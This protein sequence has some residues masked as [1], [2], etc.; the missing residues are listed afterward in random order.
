MK[1]NFNLRHRK[2]S[3]KSLIYLNFY[4][5][6]NKVPFKFNT[7]L[8]VEPKF[9]DNRRQKVI[10]K[11]QQSVEINAKLQKIEDALGKIYND[12]VVTDN[13][14]LK[15][16]LMF[17][18]KRNNRQHKNFFDFA[19]ND[20]A[21]L[22][23]STKPIWDTTVNVLKEFE[24]HFGVIGFNSFDK[25]FYNEFKK[26]C[27]DTKKYSNST[28]STRITHLKTIINNA[29][30][31][32]IEVENYNPKHFKK[33]KYTSDS[34]YLSF[35]EIKQLY[36][37]KFENK[38]LEY[39]RDFFVLR[40]FLGLR[41][42]DSEI[43]KEQ[44]I[45]M[46]GSDYLKVFTSKSKKAVY[47]PVHPYVLEILNKYDWSMENNSNEKTNKNL[48]EACKIA[49]IDSIQ[50]VSKERGGQLSFDNIPKYEMVTTHTAR[51]TVA[52]NMYLLKVPVPLIMQITGHSDYKTFINYVKVGSLELAEMAADSPFF[53]I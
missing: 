44:L 35:D 26:W 25:N 45:E 47:I 21:R 33:L 16:K 40:C 9:W 49:G 3:N 22:K 10:L 5:Q 43:H 6:G 48:K 27:M 7:K 29:I 13:S 32:N 20:N 30:D 17:E 38:E 41:F 24:H 12:D 14:I 34:V 19:Y 2:A 42:S 15:R 50:R 11:K 39:T 52:T 51:R 18:L 36:A 37:F 1:A 53:K 31:Q 46:N 4:Y 23:D 8:E 28:F